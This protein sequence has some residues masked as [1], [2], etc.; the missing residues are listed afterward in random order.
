M[1]EIPPPRLISNPECGWH[2]TRSWGEM[3][4]GG[5][6]RQYLGPQHATTP[7]S[8][9]VELDQRGRW[10]VFFLPSQAPARPPS[11]PTCPDVLAARVSLPRSQPPA[12]RIK[13]FSQ[14]P[15][16]HPLLSQAGQHDDFFFLFYQIS[17]FRDWK[18]S[19]IH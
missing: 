9:P 12:Q 10:T 13:I 16:A 2:W 8:S 18:E 17:D 11:P 14:F 15:P 3:C 4:M 19:C 5:S 1:V 7:K 6:P